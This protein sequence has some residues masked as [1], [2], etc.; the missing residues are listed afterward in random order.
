MKTEKIN[1][2]SSTGVDYYALQAY[3]AAAS[4][5]SHRDARMRGWH[6]LQAAVIGSK[7]RC[8]DWRVF[9]ARFRGLPINLRKKR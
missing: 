4:H 1:S 5:D 3:H 9:C 8:W 7:L 2:T 6:R